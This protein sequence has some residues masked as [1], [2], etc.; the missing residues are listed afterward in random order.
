MTKKK[1]KQAVTP[2]TIYRE[3]WLVGLTGDPMVTGR[4]SAAHRQIW[5]SGWRDGQAVAVAGHEFHR[6]LAS[7]SAAASRAIALRVHD[8]FELLAGPPPRAGSL[9]DCCAGLS[10]CTS[11][12]ALRPCRPGSIRGG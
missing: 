4:R 11:A 6:V 3:G 2:G 1:E 7:R 8:E 9:P 5:M 12:K 10:S